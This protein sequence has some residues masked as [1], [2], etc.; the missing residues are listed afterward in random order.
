LASSLARWQAAYSPQVRGETVAKFNFQ[1]GLKGFKFDLEGPEVVILS[2]IVAL[3]IV[4][5]AWLLTRFL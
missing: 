2:A 1:G 4:A 5:L 3:T